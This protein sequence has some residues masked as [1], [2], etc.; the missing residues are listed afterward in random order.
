M[1]TSHSPP[2]RPS[3]LI[4]TAAIGE[5]HNAAAKNLKA[6]LLKCSPSC[7]VEIHDIFQ[8]AYGWRHELL[9]KVYSA[10]IN[11]CPAAW[12]QLFGIMDRTSIVPFGVT[13]LSRATTKLRDLILSSSPTTIVATFPGYGTF[14]DFLHARGLKKNYRSITLLTDSITIHSLWYRNHSDAFITPNPQTSA[15]LEKAGVPHDRIHSLGFPVP[16]I[17]GQMPTQKS[18]P[19]TAGE[20]WKILYMVNTGHLR[21]H[22]IV[23]HLLTLENVAVTVTVGHN[24]PLQ[25]SLEKMSAHQKQSLEI[26]GWTHRMPELIARSHVL[27]GKA[28]GATVQEALAAKTPLLM[29]QII[30]GQEEGNGRLILENGAGAFASKGPEIAAKLKEAFANGGALWKKWFSAAS[31]LG[32]PDAALQIAHFITSEN[33]R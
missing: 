7:H 4:L 14:L 15:V 31:S 17:F 21:V 25:N 32:Q 3:I 18:P 10:L 16:L 33:V 20:K 29:T 13:M 22:S 1:T 6:A 30:P 26:Y 27:I 12:H 11:Y 19:T 8:E 5:G 9:G 28:G 24:K 23:K 2:S